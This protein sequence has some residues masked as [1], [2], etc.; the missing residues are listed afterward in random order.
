YLRYTGI[1]NL[2]LG[3]G[4][5]RIIYD[6]ARFVGNVGWRQDE[7][8]F[9]AFNANYAGLT[10]FTLSYTYIDEVEGITEA[11]DADTSDHLVNI[12]YTGFEFGKL[13]VYGYLLDNEDT[14]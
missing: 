1:D 9:D 10:D 13:S 3:L 7:Q 5:Q 14:G 11:F 2:D 12:G 8:T 6:N 4:R